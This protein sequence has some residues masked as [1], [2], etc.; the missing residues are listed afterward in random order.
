MHAIL[1]R[2]GLGSKLAAMAVIAVALFLIP[3]GQ[4]LDQSRDKLIYAQT[5]RLGIEPITKGIAV[6][7]TLQMHRGYSNTMLATNSQEAR[8]K[9][10]STAS[11]LQTALT[12]YIQTPF[13]KDNKLLRE[14]AQSLQSR[15]AQIADEIKQNTVQP[16]QNFANHSRLIND[17]LT[18]IGNSADE[19]GITLDPEAHTYFLYYT[20]VVLLPEMTEH[21]A[22]MRGLGVSMLA[23][24]KEDARTVGLVEAQ[25]TS[26]EKLAGRIRD[27]TSRAILSKP[28]LEPVIKPEYL[29]ANK[30]I[31]EAVAM[32]RKAVINGD[33]EGITVDSYFQT[34]AVN[35]EQSFN[36][37]QKFIDIMTKSFDERVEAAVAE[38]QMLY[39]E[40]AVLIAVL[41]VLSVLIA[42]SIIRPI[43]RARSVA[44][45]IAD[46]N[47]EDSGSRVAGSNE[48]SRLLQS[49]DDMRRGLAESINRERAVATENARIRMALDASAT[50]VAITN[51]KLDIIYTNHSLM[52]MFRE[53]E[54]DI[55]KDLPSFSS[56]SLAASNLESLFAGNPA[57]RRSAI[58]QMTGT[59]EINPV[60]GGRR[61]HLLLTPITDQGLRIGTV[62]EWQD[63]TETLARQEAEAK[64]SAE[65]ARIRSALDNADSAVMISDNDEHIIYCN[66][67]T[68]RLMREAETEIRREIPQFDAER[69]IGANAGMFRNAAGSA[70]GPSGTHQSNAVE[71]TFG[72]RVFKLFV[73]PVFAASGERLGSMLQWLD[74]TI[75]VQAERE[76]Q[77]IIENA[78]AGDFNTRLGVDGKAGFFKIL[79]ENMNRLS[80]TTSAGLQEI[81]RVLAHLS[82]G[83]LTYRITKDYAGIFGELKDN[84]NLT[85]H[86]LSEL[87][88][89][90]ADATNTI[91]SAAREIA[92]G[93]NNL[94]SRTE[95]QAANLEETASSMEE[96]TSTVQQNADNAVQAN[97]LASVAS[98]VAV[99]GG[100]VVGQ[101]V[102]TMAE[103]NDSAKKIVDIIGVIDGIAFQ[104]NIL[105][106]NAAVEAA[107]A[108]EQGRGFAVVASEVRN[109]AQR[110]ATAAKEIKG[111]IGASVERVGTGG[112]LVNEAGKTMQEIVTAIQQVASLMAEISAASGEQSA[113]IEQINKAIS[114]MDENTQQNAALVEQAAAAAESLEEQAGSLFESVGQFRL[115]QTALPSG[116]S[117]ATR[118]RSRPPAST[119]AANAG[120][121][122]KPA[123]AQASDEW[124]EF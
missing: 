61:F 8:G 70:L 68:T 63:L 92:Q 114:Q 124:E 81:G 78:A 1:N 74:R 22:R 87:V 109:L 79:A 101:V 21:I 55:R 65:N 105:A 64:K 94:S 67:A 59:E 34:L 122:P 93:N 66:A 91:N 103:I 100:Q 57:W 115:E 120:K 53:A 83:D 111:L 10:D 42:L 27:A 20:S 72:S 43:A 112:R 17:T 45:A 97:Q 9:L 98:S 89:R 5:E 32:A 13:V 47:L 51:D 96:L 23:G 3:V 25:I 110:S 35:I 88:T 18:L 15:F 16:A 117:L 44:A 84:A 121:R 14:N 28:E 73:N 71:L 82:R 60:I 62:V 2:I 52:A 49:L 24:K 56:S 41:G 46:G 77:Q 102:T 48:T 108:G 69:L 118:T 36:L 99:K 104:T 31:A 116:T 123:L 85:A 29:L 95:Q 30:N 26:A 50:N 54:N 76:V 7:R 4:L 11:E 106:L 107:R 19:T 58:E 90:I 33:S 40:L 86:N 37:N 6:L 39:I 38:R 12:A 80:D 113:G 75:E 119:G